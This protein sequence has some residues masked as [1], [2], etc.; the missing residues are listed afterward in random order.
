MRPAERCFPV[1]D[2][3]D[4]GSGCFKRNQQF[5]FNLFLLYVLRLA[6]SLKFRLDLA[7]ISLEI[8]KL[9]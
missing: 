1:L 5:K 9:S 3:L 6:V 7:W 8:S 4:L 2:G